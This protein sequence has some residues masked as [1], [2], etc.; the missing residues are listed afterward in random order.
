[1]KRL[2]T[3]LILTPT[4][5]WLVAFAP[6]GVFLLALAAVACCCLWEYLGITAATYPQYSSPQRFVPAFVA[7]LLLLFLPTH[8]WLLIV[9]TALAVMVYFTKKGPME[10]VLPLTAAVLLGV[11]Y[12]FGPWRA[13]VELRAAD[14]WWLLFAVAVNW[15]GDTFAYYGGRLFGTHRM[16]PVVSPKKTW[17]GAGSSVVASTALG[18]ALLA[19]RFPAVKLWQAVLLCVLANL[20]GQIGD[21]AESAMKRGAGVKDSGNLLPGHGGWLDRVDSSLFSVPVVYWFL[22]AAGLIR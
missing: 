3:G 17:E 10:A 19:W 8:L 16:A 11:V 9:V 14:P 21:L 22:Q 5:F 1:M 6:S 13:A 15:V 18:V 20:A 2:I 12:T 4:F 7:G